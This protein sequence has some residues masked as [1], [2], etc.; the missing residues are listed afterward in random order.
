MTKTLYDPLVEKKGREEG[1]KVKAF[2]IAR[3][4]FAKGMSLEDIQEITDLSEEEL[5]NIK[6]EE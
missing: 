2:E 5:R 4:M 1:Q 3:K 6:A